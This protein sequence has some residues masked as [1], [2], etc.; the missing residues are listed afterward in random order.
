[1]AMIDNVHTSRA[2]YAEKNCVSTPR[3]VAGL[4]LFEAHD[5]IERPRSELSGAFGPFVDQLHARSAARHPGL[6]TL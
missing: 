3:G 5:F 6:E 1:M 2:P 4:E